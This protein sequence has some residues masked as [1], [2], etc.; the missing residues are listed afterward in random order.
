MFPLF[1]VRYVQ[2]FIALGADRLVFFI[3]LIAPHLSN[4]S[5]SPQTHSHY[6]YNFTIQQKPTSPIA[7]HQQKSIENIV[8][9]L[10]FFDTP[11]TDPYQRLVLF[12]RP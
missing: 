12:L 11:H 4:T 3:A 1:H 5:L 2:H 8:L 9:Q 7:I 10:P 6:N